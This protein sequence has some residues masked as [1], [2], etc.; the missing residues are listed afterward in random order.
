MGC[1]CSMSQIKM[2][3]SNQMSVMRNKKGFNSVKS[4][5]GDLCRDII[6]LCPE[7][8]FSPIICDC[9]NIK[10]DEITT[11]SVGAQGLRP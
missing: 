4:L 7:P 1:K 10:F 6:L 5:Q 8:L 2:L 9:Y 3:Y 11:I